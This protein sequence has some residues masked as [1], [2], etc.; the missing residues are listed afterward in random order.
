ML[1]LPKSKDIQILKGYVSTFFIC[2]TIS[3]LSMINALANQTNMIQINYTGDSRLSI[4]TGDSIAAT[5]ERASGTNPV[6]DNAKR[7]SFVIVNNNNL[8][9]IA[10]TIRWTWTDANGRPRT[11]DQRSDSLFLTSSPVLNSYQQLVV[12]PG[13]FA[14][15][16]PSGLGIQGLPLQDTMNQFKGGSS[17]IAT[18]DS[19][20]FSNGSVIGLDKSMMIKSLSIRRTIASELVG[21]IENA[22]RLGKG[23]NE[24]SESYG[25]SFAGMGDIEEQRW[26]ARLVQ[27]V[28][29]RKT[30]VQ[31]LLNT[32][33]NLPAIPTE[34]H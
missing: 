20:L 11:H 21:A 25:R 1:T 13:A 3:N 7:L 9:V 26:R 19:V 5:L 4:L 22:A 27:L 18:I 30:G 28:K 8:P 33:K 31:Q 24:A 10:M 14:T 16:A 12:L 29:N 6:P 23:A 34:S 15:D 2:C 32:L 17:I